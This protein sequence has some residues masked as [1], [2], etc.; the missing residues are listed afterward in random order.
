MKKEFASFSKMFKE[1]IFSEV[2]DPDAKD[3]MARLLI[4]AYNRFRLDDFDGADYIFNIHKKEDL[5]HCLDCGMTASDISDLYVNWSVRHYSPY[6]IYNEKPHYHQFASVG[7]IY[8]MMRDSL[9]SLITRVI[10]YPY[11]DGYKALWEHCITNHMPEEFFY[12]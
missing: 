10:A 9:D 3:E 4:N 1:I 5:I 12:K 11:V 2:A 8:E 6:F 7:D